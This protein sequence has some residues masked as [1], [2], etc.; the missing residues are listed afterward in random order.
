M[1]LFLCR[2][3]PDFSC[4]TPSLTP[5]LPPNPL[6]VS[7][8]AHWHGFGQVL[9]GHWTHCLL[10]PLVLHVPPQGEITKKR[11]SHILTPRERGQEGGGFDFADVSSRILIAEPI[12]LSLPHPLQATQPQV[13]KLRETKA[14]LANLIT[15]S[16]SATTLII[17][18][19]A[20]FVSS[21]LIRSGKNSPYHPSVS[22]S[23]P[24]SL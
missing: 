8:L 11:G 5:V 20:T 15:V 19:T 6:S 3:Y 13:N 12:S 17:I 1:A 2:F 24:P 16:L 4:L 10:R 18:I 23:L 14:W 22:P 9:G 21:S 7:L